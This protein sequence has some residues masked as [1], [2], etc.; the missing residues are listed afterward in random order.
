MLRG[1][2]MMTDFW[3]PSVHLDIYRD[4]PLHVPPRCTKEAQRHH[5]KKKN[6]KRRE[7]E[8]EGERERKRESTKKTKKKQ[9]NTHTHTH[10]RHLGPMKM[11]LLEC[12]YDEKIEC[13]TTDLG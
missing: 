7:R 10:T 1:L 13:V 5:K 6:Q 3:C 4:L 12:W 2:L 9:K 11:S 8:R